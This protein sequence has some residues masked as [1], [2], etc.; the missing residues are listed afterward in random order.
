LVGSEVDRCDQ[1]GIGVSAPY[2]ATSVKLHGNPAV[3]VH[4]TAGAVRVFQEEVDRTNS[5]GQSAE[6]GIQMV[7]NLLPQSAT[8]GYPF[9]A[10]VELHDNS[11]S[12]VFHH[13]PAFEK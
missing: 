10:N 3:L 4:A 5:L 8:D 2:G 13:M 12:S 11:S 6:C 1:V 9:Q 7:F